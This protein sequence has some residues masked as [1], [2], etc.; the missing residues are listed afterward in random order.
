MLA[1]NADQPLVPASTLKVFTSLMA[2][3]YLGPGYRF[4]TEFLLDRDSNLIVKGYG[5]PLLTSEV[6]GD[7]AR[8]LAGRLR[9]F[10]DL[11]LDD[12]Y[13][14][15]PM[16]VP[17]ITDSQEPYDAPNGA[18]CVNFN[19]VNF[20][21]TGNGFVSA[22]PQT[23]LLPFVRRKLE[24]SPKLQKGRIVFS[25][26]DDDIV[27]YAG[28]LIGHFLD[29]AGVKMRG[30]I[31]LA[32]R[33]TPPGRLVW[34]HA[35]PADLAQIVQQMLKY[36]NN[37][38]ANQVFL[39]VGAEVYGPPATLDKGVRAASRYART[40]LQTDHMRLVEGSGIARQNRVSA[41]DLLAVLERFAPYRT[42]M[43]QADGVFYKT[44]TLR[45]VNTRVG[46]LEKPGA[47]WYRFVVLFN[48]PGKATASFM[49]ELRQTIE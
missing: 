37:F 39:A 48:S 34:R 43:R 44:G 46:Y 29:A 7:I 4:Q 1:K 11:V 15:K 17:G 38:M 16:A 30:R 49:R 36:S 14:E 33:P 21:R 13:F 24:A 3:H 18:L 19:T 20:S 25:H 2:L 45:G 8:K 9:H 41:R 40:E 31:R 47:G 35:A 32:E 23:P 6:I 27:R 22:E 10:Q 5:D 12:T 26:A 28:H 42:L